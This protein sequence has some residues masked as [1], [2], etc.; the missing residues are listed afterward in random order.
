MTNILIKIVIAII[1]I[2]T[3]MVVYTL[4][5]DRSELQRDG[6]EN[7]DIKNTSDIIMKEPL[8]NLC[9]MASSDSVTLDG[10]ASTENIEKLIIKG[11]RWLDFNITDK[12]GVPFASETIRFDKV[13]NVCK[14]SKKLGQNPNMPLF[15]NIRV[16]SSGPESF[17]NNIHKFILETFNEND[18]YNKPGEVKTLL[19]DTKKN[20]MEII[21]GFTKGA[22]K[23][24]ENLSKE[25]FANT[26]TGLGTEN[27]LY[28]NLT[29]L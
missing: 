23:S 11:V 6:L 3:S 1:I 8:K 24:I 28:E 15:I 14:T 19:S 26:D 21:N 9:I 4:M 25:S 2:I 12:D 20:V 29:P 13:L 17:Y 22:Y 10:V 5:R 16:T 7:K 27:E 18:L